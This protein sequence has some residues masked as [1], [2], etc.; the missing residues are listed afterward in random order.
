MGRFVIVDHPGDPDG[1]VRFLDIQMHQRRGLSHVCGR[2]QLSQGWNFEFRGAPVL[3]QQLLRDQVSVVHAGQGRI[4]SLPSI[5]VEPLLE[6]QTGIRIV[7]EDQLAVPRGP[8][9]RFDGRLAQSEGAPKG[10]QAVARN[11]GGE[12]SSVLYG[13]TETVPDQTVDELVTVL[14]KL[15]K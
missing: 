14:Q 8:H 4:R 7:E 3:G 15:M 6:G 5:R 2:Q 1:L 13:K 11:V 12:G 9:V 10:S